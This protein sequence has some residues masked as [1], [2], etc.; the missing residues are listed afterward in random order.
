M[1]GS[2]VEEL[3]A[4]LRQMGVVGQGKDTDGTKQVRLFFFDFRNRASR[5]TEPLV[6]LLVYTWSL[7]T[8]ACNKQ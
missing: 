1:R 5:G 2:L 7:C 6:A 8:K 3:G 4:E